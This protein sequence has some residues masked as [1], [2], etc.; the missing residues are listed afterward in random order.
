MKKLLVFTPYPNISADTRYR[1]SQFI[2]ILEDDGWHVNIRP[3]MDEPFFA[4]Y[5]SQGKVTEKI[6]RTLI[7]F[8]KRLF[9]L[10]NVRKYDAVF[11]HKE[12]FPFGPP[13]FEKFIKLL[14][15]RIIY[16]LDDAFWTHPP[17]FRQIGKIFRDPHKIEKIVKLSNLVLAGNDYLATYVR[18]FNK[19]TILF[20]TVL[21]L[22]YYKFR[23]EQDDGIVTIGWVGRWSSQ[24]YLMEL[25]NVFKKLSEKFQN[26]KFLFIGVSQDFSIEGI[27][28]EIIDW[29]LAREISDINLID[30]GIMP[31]PDDEYSKG[32]CGFKLLQYM[33]LGIPAV[34]SSVGVNTEIVIDG[35]NGFLA[36]T[37][38]EWEEKLS[39]LIEWKLLRLEL[40]MNARKT[41]ESY[42]SMQEQALV[43]LSLLNNLLIPLSY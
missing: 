25:R 29:S 28:Y 7:G 33:A 36:S 8:I 42:Y 11:I 9:Q 1:I 10:H 27:D 24:V 5:N 20:P 3:F 30:I 38:N 2:P 6:I 39:R 35:K 15:P 18:K 21:D 12:I 4:M 19:N 34:A 31:L 32:K 37:Q 16:D 26:V 23:E 40:G 13:V 14:C 41:V 22:D 43:L 17:Q